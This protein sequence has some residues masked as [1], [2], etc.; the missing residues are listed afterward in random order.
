[1]A[2][3]LLFSS[4]LGKIA[5]PVL[6]EAI[7][8]YNIENQILELRETLT[9]IKAV[10][11]DAEV[12][13]AKN[14][15][16]QVWLDQ[17]Q[18]A[19]YDAEDV[20]D[21]LECEALRKQV[22][23]RYGGVKGK[24]R[25]FFSTSNPL[26]FRAEISHKIKE[27]RERLSKISTKK[28]Q[29]NLN[30]WSVDN[31]V[32]HTRSRETHSFISNLDVVG[33]NID[34]EK[35][36]EMLMRPDDKNLSVFPIVGIGG[37]GKTTLAKLVY[38]DDK[39]KEQFTLR[40]WVCVPEDF[41]LRKT[42]EGI[43]KDAT[44]QDLSIFDIEQLQNSLQGIIKDKKFILV[45]DY[46]WSNDRRRWKELRELLSRGASESKIIV[47]TRSVEVASIVGTHP[48]HNLKGLS[49]ED[50]MA[51]F[52]KWAFDEKEKEPCLDLLEI[53]NDIVKK[54][55]GIPLL[56]TTL[57][58]LLYS[59]N[60]DRH[61][62]HIRDSE[63]WE[64]V[65]VKKD[66]VPI[67][68]LSYDHLPSHLRRCFA[69]FSLYPRGFRMKAPYVARLWMAL[70]LIGSKR[71]KLALEDVGIDYIKELWK[72]SLI[73][74]VEEYGPV[75][76]FKVHDLIHSLAISVAQND[77]SIVGLD[78]TDI[79][80]GVSCVSFSSTS[81]EG[82]SNFDGVPPFLR[83]PTSKR[84]HAI[85]FQNQVDDGVITREFARTCI[86][87][88]NHIR[89]LDLSRGSFEELPRSIC[90][91]KQLRSLLLDENK[92]L[93][94]LPST[95]CKLQSLLELSLTGCSKLGN[96]PKNMKRLVSLRYLN[97]T[98]KQKSLQESG[99]QYM[100]NLHFLGVTGCENLEVF[101]EGASRLTRLQL[102]KIGNY[103]GPISLLFGDLIALESLNID[104]CK[105]V[106][107]LEN[108]SNFPFNL[109]TLVISNSKQVMELLQY[110]E[111]SVCTLES[112]CIL[113]SLSFT[114]IPEWL[115][116]QTRLRV[117]HLI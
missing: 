110:L 60:D 104:T 38:N 87:K 59:R 65:E 31:G 105:F 103:E 90:N 76:T 107:T 101:F 27:I 8:I 51:L 69:A 23:S 81:L 70:G 35:I 75:L 44:P 29:F 113:D 14:A 5:S 61:W 53:G 78:T 55:Q 97:I 67:L 106:L 36:I 24:V 28:D 4:V 79:S 50:S 17:L 40:R 13:Q 19:F 52:K 117:F 86:S 21:E 68:K 77:C 57:G 100:E 74:E 3:S 49:H 34:K 85:I 25:R 114:T 46:V 98:T 37:L 63:T 73:Q 109:R 94:K 16:L 64:L 62:K 112:L 9:A 42:I 22:I 54:T 41:D 11:L 6:Q 115:P 95:I 93:K 18:H 96:L 83:K 80:E 7:A 2:E 72:R 102:L 91:L 20:L 116:N 43:I 89:F 82:I 10:L 26:M 30:M 66:I 111:G 58:S 32:G 92:Q 56:V 33:R 15:L 108:K 45:L 12:R 39:V 48:V 71:E 88:C 84:L 99:I 1:M 47:T